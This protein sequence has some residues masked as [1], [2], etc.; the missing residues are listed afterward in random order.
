[1]L[2]DIV[3][4]N[5]Y[6]VEREFPLADLSILSTLKHSHILTL[7]DP[8]LSLFKFNMA[9]PILIQ[10]LISNWPALT[11]WKSPSFWISSAGHRFFPVEIGNNYLSEDWKQEIIQLNEYFENYVFKADPDNIAYIAQHNW[12]YQLPSLSQD[13]TVPDL[14]DIFLNSIQDRPLIHMWFGMKNTMSPLHF[15]NYNNIFTQITGYKHILLVDPKF[16]TAIANG[17][18]SNTC[19]IESVNLLNFLLMKN[20]PY[21]E[22]ILKPGESLYIPKFWWHQVKSISF[23]ISISFWF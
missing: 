4:Q 5:L 21:H 14:C 7:K 17:S 9:N 3:C 16:S 6:S 1:M 13:F 20:I 22:L 18:N 2:K 11:K 23:S 10:E 19:N 15:D 12:L 8:T